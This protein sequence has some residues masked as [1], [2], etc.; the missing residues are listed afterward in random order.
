MKDRISRSLE[1]DRERRNDRLWQK[2]LKTMA[3]RKEI[4][5]NM[6][7]SSYVFAKQS[8]NQCFLRLQHSQPA[9]WNPSQR[10]PYNTDYH[11]WNALIDGADNSCCSGRTIEQDKQQHHTH[12][13]LFVIQYFFFHYILLTGEN[14][15]HLQKMAF[16]L[17]YATML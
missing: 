8:E 15:A 13:I 5:R 2:T 16:F 11:H 6:I 17:K 9:K 7:Q 12:T 3:I 1:Y 4:M 10:Q 14:S